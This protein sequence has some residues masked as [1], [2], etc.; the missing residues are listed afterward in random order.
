MSDMASQ[1]DRVL[2]ALARA[3][4]A[5]SVHNTQPARWALEDQSATVLCDTDCGLA[6]GDPKGRD[7]ALSCG[8]ALEAMVLALSAEGLVAEVELMTPPRLEPGQG[9]VPLAQL[10]IGDGATADPLH[11][12]LEQRFTWRGPFGPGPNDL[13][14]WSRGDSRLVLDKANRDWLAARNDTASLQIL[15]DRA[16]RAE[17]VSWMRLSPRHPRHGLDGMSRAAMRLSPIEALG[18]RGVLGPLW[19]VLDRLGLTGRLTAEAEATRSA[20]VIALFHRPRAENPAESGRAY[21]RLCLEAAALGMAGWPMAALSDHPQ[22]NA[23]ICSRFALPPDRR[24][25]QAIRFGRPTGE[26]PPRA[27]RPLDEVLVSG[28]G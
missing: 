23:E 4:L 27:R 13:H 28:P 14:S 26:A 10:R 19:P 6:S 5:P 9:L 8:A 7:A 22:I 21:L 16:V 2:R 11:L 20:A 25:V 3:A 18:V 12:Q 24:L 1:R 15:R 17:L